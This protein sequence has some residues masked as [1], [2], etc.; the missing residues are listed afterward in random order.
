MRSLP[1]LPAKPQHQATGKGMDIKISLPSPD[2]M[3]VGNEAYVCV[4]SGTELHRIHPMKFGSSQLNPSTDGDARFSPIRDSSGNIIPTVYAAESFEC[5]VCE[6]ILR[7]PDMPA[8]STDAIRDV[9]PSKYKEHAHS[10][11]T[12]NRDLKLVDLTI[13]GQ[14]SIG[15]EHNALL[16]GSSST[17]PTTRAWAERI[18]TECQDAQ[19]IYYTSYQWGPETAILVFGDRI[20]PDTFTDGA[21]RPVAENACHREIVKLGRELDI[22]YIDI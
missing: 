18:H 21:I 13:K 7:C 17:Y 19:G 10:T 2:A 16:A 6:I 5:A 4:L 9:P 12:L 14:R 15:V 3:R 20:E 11:L 1:L 22:E 8:M